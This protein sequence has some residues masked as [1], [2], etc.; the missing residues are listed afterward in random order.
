VSLEKQDFSYNQNSF[1]LWTHDDFHIIAMPNKNR[2]FT[3]NLFMPL[4]GPVSFDTVKT[5]E[6]FRA[7]M[8]R[9]FPELAEV[10]VFPPESQVAHLFDYKC[11]PWRFGN[12]C[13]FGNAAH[14]VFP[15]FGQ[16]LNAS[17][18][19]CNIMSRLIDLHGCDWPQVTKAFQEARKP[20]TDAISNLSKANFGSLKVQM[21]DEDFQEKKQILNYLSDVYPALFTSQYQMIEFT[22]TDFALACRF[23]RVEEEII[24]QVRMIPHYQK[25]VESGK[26][27]SVIR[28]ILR[29]FQG[30]FDVDTTVVEIISQLGAESKV[31]H[32]VLILPQIGQID[33]GESVNC[34][35]HSNLSLSD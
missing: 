24:K 11:Y 29:S 3:C 26:E 1:H 7:F 33:V 23:G 12:F 6:E 22:D 27:E 4:E 31:N 15:Y 17:L 30:R 34:S 35:I 8:A 2:T 9:F 18:E 5:K 10:M 25:L 32:E 14:C 20:N 28:K 13:L 21:F 19:D 16:G